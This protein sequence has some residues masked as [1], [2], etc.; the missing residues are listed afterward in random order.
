MQRLSLLSSSLFAGAKGTEVFSLFGNRYKK[1]IDDDDDDGN[2]E[3][4]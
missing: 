1:C 2:D 4:G 3:R